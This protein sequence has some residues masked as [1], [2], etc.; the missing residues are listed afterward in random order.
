MFYVYTRER[1][2][3][4]DLGFDNIGEMFKIDMEGIK[5][6][7]NND[8]NVLHYLFVLEIVSLANT[9]PIFLNKQSA[10]LPNAIF[11]TN[12]KTFFRTMNHYQSFSFSV[13]IPLSCVQ[14]SFDNH[15][16]FLHRYGTFVVNNRSCSNHRIRS[17]NAVNTN[18]G[19]FCEGSQTM[20][21]VHISFG[22]ELW[23]DPYF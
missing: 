20:I 19:H 1:C 16:A 10:I 8:P 15:T 6:Q 22:E 2:W 17:S 18:G 3:Q 5:L 12:R 14:V 4:F 21:D 23:L 11:T 9:R 13:L 7:T